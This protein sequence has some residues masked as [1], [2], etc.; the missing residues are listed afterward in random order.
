MRSPSPLAAYAESDA[1]CIVSFEDVRYSYDGRNFALAGIN[2]SINRGEF[3]CVVGGNGSGKST[4]AKHINALI[5]PD[6]GIVRVLGHDTRDAESTFLIRSNAAMV[7]QNPDDQ[8]VASIVE[9]E[10]AFGPENLGVAASEL[11]E[12]VTH[13]LQRVGLD[14]FEARETHSLSGGEKQRLAI[15]G[16]LAMEPQ[17]IVFDEASAM[18]DARGRAELM[19]TCRELNEAGLTI[20]LITHFMEEAV[21]ADRVIV[22]AA[23]RIVLNGTPRKVFARAGRLKELGLDL[24]F[25]AQMSSALR[26]DGVAVDLHIHETALAEEV[27]QLL[28]ETSA[29]PASSQLLAVPAPSREGDDPAMPV[30]NLENVSFTYEPTPNRGKRGR[31]VHANDASAEHG[32]CE[33]ARWAIRGVSLNVMRGELV[34]IVGHTGSG[35]STLAQLAAGLLQPSSGRVALNGAYLD[36]KRAARDVANSVG[37]VFQYPERQLFAATVFDDV[38]F[39]PR[40]LGLSADAVESRVSVALDMVHLQLDD[41]RD[42]SPF[43]LSGGQQRN[44]AIAGVLAMEPLVLIMDEPTAG[45]DP[46][47]RKALLSLIAELRDK[48]GL[49]V[50]LVSHDMDDLAYL[51]DRIMVL[52]QGELVI[53]GKPAD[54]FAEEATL[55]AIGLSVPRT[56]RLANALGI[57]M[58]DHVPTVEQLAQSIAEHFNRH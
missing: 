25:A 48:R 12:R 40:N 46:N 55:D 21:N 10:V 7:F 20:V 13:A 8:I 24:P 29:Q 31:V 16:A 4:L 49:T 56:M 32:A 54:V 43:A 23:G 52:N 28:C 47:A 57:D 39:G 41:L 15:A 17:I 37:L 2:L 38:A 30:I 5:T 22:L 53:E 11:R 1:K 19:R 18:L 26:E 45:L 34:G 6:E 33:A 42:R 50:M 44:V 51:C 58:H 35:K 36:D 3:V 27:R 9:D 14:G